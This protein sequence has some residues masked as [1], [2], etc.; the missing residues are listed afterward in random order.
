M[1]TTLVGDGS[2][3]SCFHQDGAKQFVFTVVNSTYGYSRPSG[4]GGQVLFEVRPHNTS[5]GQTVLSVTNSVHPQCIT[6]LQKLNLGTVP[7]PAASL[8]QHHVSMSPYAQCLSIA[9]T[10]LA[11]ISLRYKLLTLKFEPR[12]R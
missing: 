8:Y 4:L 9:S 12:A 10:L 11:A 6:T 5:S 2:A 3:T 7:S 1:Q